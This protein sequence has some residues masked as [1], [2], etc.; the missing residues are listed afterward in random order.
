LRNLALE[1]VELQDAGVIVGNACVAEENG[2][3]AATGRVEAIWPVAL[4]LPVLQQVEAESVPVEAQTGL[5][6]ADD[7][8]PVG[9]RFYNHPSPCLSAATASG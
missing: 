2:S 6:V 9:F 3:Q 8:G 5:E 4:D 1:H 7:L